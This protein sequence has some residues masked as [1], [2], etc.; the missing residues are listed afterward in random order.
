MIA[1]PL[2]S[3]RVRAPGCHNYKHPVHAQAPPDEEPR[4][5][6]ELARRRSLHNAC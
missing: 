1:G 5:L 3:A 6:D 2:L 4:W